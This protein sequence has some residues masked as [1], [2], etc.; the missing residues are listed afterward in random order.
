MFILSIP[1]FTTFL[2]KPYLPIF[3]NVFLKS[4]CH[5]IPLLLRL[6]DSIE[7]PDIREHVYIVM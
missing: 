6:V 3:K 2:K 4:D 5:L 7:Q 1:Y